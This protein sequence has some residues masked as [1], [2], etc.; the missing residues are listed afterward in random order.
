MPRASLYNYAKTGFVT[1]VMPT[2]FHLIGWLLSLSV[3]L[4]WEETLRANY[5]SQAST[6]SRLQT[7]ESRVIVL[8]VL[9]VF[10]SSRLELG[11]NPK[12]YGRYGILLNSIPLRGR[13]HLRTPSFRCEANGLSNL[14]LSS[15][16]SLHSLARFKPFM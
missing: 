1:F 7:P 16:C 15:T 12:E 3:A 2:V 8:I 5:K 4:K 9:I 11:L 10:F 13:A 6:Q 14:R